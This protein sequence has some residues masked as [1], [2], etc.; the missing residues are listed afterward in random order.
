MRELNIKREMLYLGDDLLIYIIGGKAHIGS[1][2]NA[3]AYLKDEEWHV[4][5]NTWKRLTHKDDKIASMYAKAA[6]MITH[7]VVCCVCGIHFDHISNKEIQE[8]INWCQNDIEKM[9][10]ELKNEQSI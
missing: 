1:C 7:K 8:I 2:V 4:T 6:S 10:K 9:E 5:L 3:E